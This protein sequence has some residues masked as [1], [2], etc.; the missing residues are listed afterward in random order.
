MNYF[1]NLLR[2]NSGY[3]YSQLFIASISNSWVIFVYG[4]TT[5]K[6]TNNVLDGTFL[7]Y[8]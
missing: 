8:S 3:F 2:I 5:S 7:V 6:D 1:E 4:L